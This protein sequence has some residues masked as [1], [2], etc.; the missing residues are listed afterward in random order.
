MSAVSAVSVRCT[1]RQLQ[2]DLR[3]KGRGVDLGGLALVVRQEDVQIVPGP[4][5]QRDVE[6]K[7]W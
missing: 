7:A 3:M 6:I 1:T 5:W 4:K 2:L